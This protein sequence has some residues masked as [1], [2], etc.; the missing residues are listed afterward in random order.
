MLTLA[1]QEG[2][3]KHIDN[4]INPSWS[5]WFISFCLNHLLP[6]CLIQTLKLEYVKFKIHEYK[7]MII[8]FVQYWMFGHFLSNFLIILD[9][10]EIW[11]P[12]IQNNQ[13]IPRSTTCL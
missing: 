6:I 7:P 10:K 1:K 13:T 3:N 9:N 5:Y 4:P 11:K 8:M 12:L 2:F